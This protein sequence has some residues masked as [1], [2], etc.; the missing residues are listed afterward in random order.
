MNAKAGNDT[1]RPS[2]ILILTKKP[3]SMRIAKPAEAITVIK[4]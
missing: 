4:G 2:L 3:N 1:N